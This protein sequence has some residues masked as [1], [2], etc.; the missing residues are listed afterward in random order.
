MDTQEPLAFATLAAQGGRHPGTAGAVVAPLDSST[1]YARD[2]HYQAANGRTYSRDQ[3]PTVEH[4]EVA[5][6]Q[7]EGGHSTLLFASGMAAAS[8]V[9]HALSPGDRICMPRIM[10]WS[11]R[12][13]FQR[14]ADRW[15][16]GIDLFDAGEPTAL[17]RALIP[18][19]TKLLWV[20]PLLN[21]TWDVIDIRAA[22][23]AARDAG[24]RLVVDATAVSPVLCRPLELGADLVMHSAT[25]YLNGHSDVV[26]GSLTTGRGDDFWARVRDYRANGGAVLG[27][28]EAWLL[29]RGLRTVHLRVERASHNAQSIAEHFRGHAKLRAVL[30][31][32]LQNHPGFTTAKRQMKGGFG[33]MLSLRVRG[34]APAALN[35]AKHV[36]LFAR[37]T[38]LGGV[39]SLIE[40]RA[41]VEGPQSPIPEDLLRLSVGIEDAGDLVRDLEQALV[42]A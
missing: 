3:N 31:P 26:A 11:L 1:T 28:F 9:L 6:N 13:W 30:Y 4:A 40:H 37:A 33:G 7:L 32:G 20:E 14:F 23:A 22:A 17:E 35:V 38:S 39:E 19:R 42:A 29:L 8:A 36:E 41:S 18:G 5:L 10:Y 25:K 34:G 21:P 27:A 12:N 24:A 15:G 16:L 2:Q